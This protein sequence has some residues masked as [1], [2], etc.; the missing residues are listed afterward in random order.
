MTNNNNETKKIHHPIDK[1]FRRFFQEKQIIQELLV[2]L[3]KQSWVKD[4]DFTTL[5]RVERSYITNNFQERA[6]DVIW[7]IKYKTSDIYID[8]LTE[9]QSSNDNTMPIRILDYI[10]S[11]YENEYKKL[12]IGEKIIPMIPIVFYVGSEKWTAVSKFHDLVNIPNNSLKKFIPEFEYI[13][14]NIDKINTE[15]LLE[16][17]SMLTNIV[18][19]N[20]SKNYQELKNI[21]KNLFDLI[22]KF[23]DEKDIKKYKEFLLLY[24]E[25]VLNKKFDK[26]EA[27]QIINDIEG[28][29]MFFVTLDHI[30]QQEKEEGE[31]KGKLEGKLEAAKEML[32]DNL[33]IEIIIKYSGLTIEEIEKIKKEMKDLQNGVDKIV[34]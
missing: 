3:V 25:L 14:I 21:S 10:G 33:D 24:I 1:F 16:A 31:K 17:E 30:F 12:N 27:K 9:I 2:H 34:K 4:L 13:I 5:E 29:S 23:K 7:K 22:I 28:G 18:A 26:K 15:T 6:S 32:K 8:V 11:F 19:M 20:K